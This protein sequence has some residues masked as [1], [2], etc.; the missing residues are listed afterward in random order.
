MSLIVQRLELE[1]TQ[2]ILLHR[3]TT[4]DSWNLELELE[5]LQLSHYYVLRKVASSHLGL[6]IDLNQIFERIRL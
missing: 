3:F 6:K 5:A 2:S 4:T 1:V